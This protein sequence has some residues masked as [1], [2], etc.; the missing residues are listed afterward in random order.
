VSKARISR[1][2]VVYEIAV[3]L[4][5]IVTGLLRVNKRVE[6]EFGEQLPRSGNLDATL[7]LGQTILGLVGN[8]G[9]SAAHIYVLASLK[10]VKSRRLGAGN[11]W[12]VNKL[13]TIC[14]CEVCFT[15]HYCKHISQSEKDFC[16]EF[17]L[18]A[19]SDPLFDHDQGLRLENRS[20]I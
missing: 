11:L 7:G 2:Q 1:I 16:G 15:A 8:L 5:V 13:F 6:L 12:R 17:L 3:T 20:E 9:R 18:A 14:G 10:Y 19:D 4:Q